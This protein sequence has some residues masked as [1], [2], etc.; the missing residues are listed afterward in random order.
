MVWTSNGVDAN[1]DKW[2]SK[3]GTDW[4]HDNYPNLVAGTENGIINYMNPGFNLFQNSPNPFNSTTTI[5]FTLPLESNVQISIYTIGG[6]L[7]KNLVNSDFSAGD[8]F[9]VWSC[10]E[11]MGKTFSDGLYFYKITASDFIE[12]KKMLIIK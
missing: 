8:H 11:N 9:I 12:T 7:V 5:G 6:N 3:P 2:D 1:G 4:I 10:S